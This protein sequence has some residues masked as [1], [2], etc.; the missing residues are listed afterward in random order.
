M[1]R[2]RKK[3]RKKFR[4]HLEKKYLQ[5]ENHSSID[6][7]QTLHE[8]QVR[9]I[10]MDMQ[11]EDLKL[12]NRELES[13]KVF[14]QD[15]YNK[16]PVGYLLV[17]V[18]GIIVKAN[19][20]IVSLL[21]YSIFHL[22]NSELSRFIFPEDQDTY[23]LHIKNLLLSN[24]PQ[25]CEL[26][27]KKANQGVLWVRLN[28]TFDQSS[29]LK[30]S[31]FRMIL[32]DISDQKKLEEKTRRIRQ[33]E[34]IGALAGGIAHD[35]NNLLA[36][37]FGYLELIKQKLDDKNSVLENIDRSMCY[38][39]KTQSLTQK[40][41][42]ISK[43]SELEKK[44]V[45]INS[46]LIEISKMA[47]LNSKVSLS[48]DLCST[49][50]CV[51][52]DVA[53]IKQAIEHLIC[54]AAEAMATGGRIK[55]VTKEVTPDPLNPMFL[56]SHLS[57]VSVGIYDEGAGIPYYLLDKIFEPFFTTK[58]NRAGL[59]LAIVHSIIVRHG[60]FTQV[61]TELRKGSHFTLYLP[62]CHKSDDTNPK[63]N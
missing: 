25:N 15:L 43:G 63:E 17:S 38:F 50:T 58:S 53:Q 56:S 55:F 37:L 59:G 42:T 7:I 19:L 41:A 1:E 61:E 51:N 47:T 44:V 45:N 54:N 28:S 11:F 39:H 6:L 57:W 29:N 46:L 40:L 52:V 22:D 18:Q 60:G 3:I 14:Y 13:S 24:S 30:P 8:F 16:A 5:H 4:Y 2:N 32:T 26:R 20:T 33:L 62:A 49:L 31:V 27:M 10:E 23:Y 34:C 9:Q 48:F 35:L 12:S 36:G 21:G